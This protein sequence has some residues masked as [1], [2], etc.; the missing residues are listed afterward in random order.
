VAHLTGQ[1]CTGRLPDD[2]DAGRSYAALLGHERGDGTEIVV[3]VLFMTGTVGVFAV[4][5][6]GPGERHSVVIYDERFHT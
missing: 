3:G 2:P 4:A 6:R 5:G 1:H